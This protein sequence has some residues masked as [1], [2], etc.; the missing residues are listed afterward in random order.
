MVVLLYCFMSIS[1]KFNRFLAAGYSWK[2]QKVGI[3]DLMSF[4]AVNSQQAI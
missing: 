2:S 4:S 1:Q 3:W